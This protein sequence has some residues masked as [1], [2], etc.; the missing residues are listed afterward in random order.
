M[1]D[2]GDLALSPEGADEPVQDQAALLVDRFI[3]HLS[4]ERGLSGHTVRAY[5]TDLARYL[6]WCERSSVDPVRP[7]H[8]AL[9]RYLADLDRARYARTTIKRRLSSVR[10]FFAW[11]VAE[12]IVESD[13]ASVLTA[14]KT[15]SRLPR[16]VPAEELAALLGAPDP[17]TPAGL[18]DRALLEML[19]ASG[20]RVSEISNLTLA[21][22]D[23][24][25][26]QITVMGKGSKERV[27]PVHPYAAETLRRYLREGRPHLARESSP[28]SVFLSVR[29]NR[30]SEDAIRRL[31]KRYLAQAGASSALSP[32]AMRHTFAT[33]L[34]DAGADLRTVQELLGHVA[35]S[36]TQIY[37]HVSMKRL[38]DVHRTTHPRA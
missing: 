34:L 3:R 12:G 18:R 35:L 10:A 28:E 33:H 23:L 6:E 32:H 7:D 16:L 31:F 25:Q 17:S 21:G 38:R 22:L 14:P 20:A 9:R 37:T 2:T 36:T 19:Y 4:V 27:L 15:P 11:L 5:A 30:L 29:G 8:R 24:A 26:G 13:P 1:S